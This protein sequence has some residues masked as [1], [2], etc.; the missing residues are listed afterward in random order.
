MFALWPQFLVY[1]A[2]EKAPRRS[3]A[4][5]VPILGCQGP[6]MGHNLLLRRQR[7][8]WHRDAG[9]WQ[10]AATRIRCGWFVLCPSFPSICLGIPFPGTLRHKR[11]QRR[12]LTNVRSV[13]TAPPEFPPPRPRFLLLPLFALAPEQTRGSKAERQS[14]T[15]AAAT[16]AGCLCPAP[17][18]PAPRRGGSAPGDAP[19]RGR[20]DPPCPRRGCGG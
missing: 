4:G 18:P 12:C 9:Q 7:D 8:A 14:S 1:G 19:Q 20:T 16:A 11:D 15:R 17:L 2:A 10:P 6:S 5:R 13:P 3:P